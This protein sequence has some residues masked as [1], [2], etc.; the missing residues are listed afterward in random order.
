MLLNLIGCG[1]TDARKVSPGGLSEAEERLLR[2]S[3]AKYVTASS[4]T[5][6][7]KEKSTKTS[8]IVLRALNE[9]V[10][11]TTRDGGEAGFVPGPRGFGN[12]LPLHSVKLQK[13]TRQIRVGGEYREVTIEYPLI[14][15]SDTVTF[16]TPP[17]PLNDRVSKLRK[18]KR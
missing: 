18:G 17:V 16:P 11:D 6:K 15:D 14:P 4:P 8:A 2:E 9:K 5:G 13:A 10:S 7:S 1:R 12:P 3:Q